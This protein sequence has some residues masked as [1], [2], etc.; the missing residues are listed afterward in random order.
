MSLAGKSYLITGS[1]DGIGRHTANLLYLSGARVYIHGRDPERIQQTINHIS[2]VKSCDNHD[3]VLTGFVADFS[4]FSE[5]RKL[6]REIQSKVE[7]PFTAIINNAGV[8]MPEKVMTRDG[9]EMTWQVNVASPFLLTSLLLSANLIDE[10]IVNVASI[11]AGFSI[12]FL[13]TQ[14]EKG[15]SAHGAYSLSK[16]ANIIFSNTLAAKLKGLGS[17]LTSNSLDPGTVNT[18][19]LEAGWGPIGIPVDRANDQFFAVTQAE[20]NGKYFVSQRERS[21]PPPATDPEIQDSL[22][23]LLCQQTGAQWPF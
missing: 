1:T 2:S 9:L 12:D 11:S 5:V 22:W 8:Y 18:K 17:Q 4:S 15:Y 21:P 10:K 16:L 3:D 14:Q 19:M 23:T 20:G 7:Y 13:N 6:A